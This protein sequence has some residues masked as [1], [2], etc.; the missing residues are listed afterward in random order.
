MADVG[1]IN[2]GDAI[3]VE[4]RGR[5]RAQGSKKTNPRPLPLLLHRLFRPSAA[6]VVHWVARTNPTPLLQPQALPNIWT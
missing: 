1:V 5:G 6:T 3:M 2:V 4:K